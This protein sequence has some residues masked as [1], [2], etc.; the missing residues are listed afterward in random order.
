MM[1]KNKPNIS[2]RFIQNVVLGALL[3]TLFLLVCRLFAPFFTVL[4]WSI[5][6]YVVIDPLYEKIVSKINLET[7]AGKFLRTILAGFF[8]LASVLIVFVPLAIVV[9][10]LYIQ[11]IQ[12]FKSIKTYI[13][14]NREA[15]NTA[16]TSLSNF[17][18]DATDGRVAFASLDINGKLIVF[19]E[20]NVFNAFKFSGVVLR[21]AAVFLLG[22]ALVVFCLFFFYLDA[23]YLS[24][25]VKSVIPIRNKYT[26][27]LAR[28]FKEIT[29]GLILG[30]LTVALIQAALAFIIFSI[31]KVN[32]ALVFACLTFV[33]VFIPMLGGALVWIPVGAARILSGDIVGGVLLTLIA[34]VCISLL[35]NF[36][37]PF[38]LKDRLKLHPLVIFFAIMG[39]LVLFGVNGLILGPLI[40]VLFLTVLEMF[41]KEHHI[42][43]RKVSIEESKENE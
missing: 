42:K 16:Y 21:D 6:L 31:F 38:L 34:A 10:Q 24:S 22:L 40:I 17:V 2:G 32:G 27:A 29:R 19:I 7:K 25:L 13:L 8:A 4:L 9:S 18:F 30:Y 14:E 28:K 20:D 39:G 5:L 26:I 15:I 33:C 37:R 36:I 35:D 3:V 41:F 43:K 23:P 1:E 11:G 12:V